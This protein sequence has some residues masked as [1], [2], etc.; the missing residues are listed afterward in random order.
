MSYLKIGPVRLYISRIV[1]I[2]LNPIYLNL[3][4]IYN[5]PEKSP[6]WILTFD[7]FILS[8]LA[9]S[10]TNSKNNSTSI[11]RKGPLGMIKNGGEYS[12]LSWRTFKLHEKCSVCLVFTMFHCEAETISDWNHLRLGEAVQ[13]SWYQQ[14]TASAFLRSLLN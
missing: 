2:R 8:H 11:N 7:I 9:S 5:F 13:L 14:R 6:N 4:M 3:A 1:K 10:L 12:Q